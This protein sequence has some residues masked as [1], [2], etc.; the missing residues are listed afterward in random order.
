MV[1][2]QL[3]G[4]ERHRQESGLPSARPLPLP[5]APAAPPLPA[6]PTRRPLLRPTWVL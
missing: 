4:R 1:L 3:R 2:A 6:L 5:T